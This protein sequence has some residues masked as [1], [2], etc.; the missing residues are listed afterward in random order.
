[1]IVT[2]YVGRKLRG[3]Y[4]IQERINIDSISVVYKAYDNVEDRIVVIKILQEENLN[5]EK[6]KS[7]FKSELIKQLNH[8]NI[9]H[10]Y[11]VCVGEK[12]QYIVMEYIDGITLKEYI[13]KQGSINWYDVIYFSKSILEAVQYAHNKNI[14]HG[15]ITAENILLTANAEVKIKDFGI[16]NSN[17]SH[18]KYEDI[19]NI[20]VLIY[21]MLTGELFEN[22]QSF[23]YKF[24][25]VQRNIKEIYKKIPTRH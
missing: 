10:I 3:R 9:A 25:Y 5:F 8:I 1:M 14:I 24:S 12:L 13:N 4:E 16:Y 18:Q 21:E 11:D 22:V 6:F 19:G 23:Q 17:S 20:G 2:D 15:N 7:T